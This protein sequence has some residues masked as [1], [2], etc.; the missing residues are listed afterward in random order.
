MIQP[1]GFSRLSELRKISDEMKPPAKEPT[2]PRTIVMRIPILCRPG[3]RKRAIAPTINPKTHQPM[4][5]IK[6]M[7]ME[8]SQRWRTSDEM[9]RRALLRPSAASDPCCAVADEMAR[10][11]PSEQPAIGSA[12]RGGKCP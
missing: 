6:E 11:E 12:L 5:P 1:A 3:I 8:T 4:T 10:R 7:F 9:A 2:T